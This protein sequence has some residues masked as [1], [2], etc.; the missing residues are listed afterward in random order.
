[1]FTR[2][3]L[4]FTIVPAVEL[5]LLIRV[6]EYIGA[7]RTVALIVLTGLVGATLAKREGLGILASLQRELE[8]GR[9]PTDTLVQ[10]LLVLAGGLFLVTPGVLTDITG[11]LCILPPT[12]TLFAAGLRRAFAGKVQFH[13]VN[14]GPPE[15]SAGVRP[16]QGA[17]E[18]PSEPGPSTFEHPIR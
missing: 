18:R 13:G 5:Y 10:G 11:F 16:S 3:F 2:L 6:G 15:S 7:S 8:A 4:L 1:M 17:E 12:R 14:L 9:A